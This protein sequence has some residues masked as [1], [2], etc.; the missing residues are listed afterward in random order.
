M[1]KAPLFNNDCYY[2]YHFYILCYGEKCSF[3]LI[4]V[5]PLW[6]HNIRV[7]TKTIKLIRSKWNLSYWLV[8]KITGKSC[9]LRAGEWFFKNSGSRKILVEFHRSRSLVFWAVMYVCLAVS[10]FIQRCQTLWSLGL[11]ILKVKMSRG[12]QRKMLVSPSHKVLHYHSPP[13]III[14]IVGQKYNEWT[15]EVKNPNG[16]EVDQLATHKHRTSWS[17][18][19][20]DFKSSALITWPP[21]L[22]YKWEMKFGILKKNYFL[23]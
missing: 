23:L 11:T 12:S 5:F 3:S 2:Y 21:C 1:K 7:I 4:L 22:T 17:T 14:S 19:S 18:G 8:Y 6:I 9:N 13:L 16:H 20:P 10:F 15:E